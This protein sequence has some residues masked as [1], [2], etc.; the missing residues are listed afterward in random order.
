MNERP[1]FI[2]SQKERFDLI[3]FFLSIKIKK[4]IFKFEI[5]SKDLVFN[6]NSLIF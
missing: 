5:V 3:S 6:S 4:H 2:C 1:M